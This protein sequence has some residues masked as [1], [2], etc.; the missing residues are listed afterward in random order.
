MNTPNAE[1]PEQ[2][3]RKD[4]DKY[5]CRTCGSPDIMVLAWVDGN[6]GTPLLEEEVEYP[7]VP[8]VLCRGCEAADTFFLIPE[9]P[10]SASTQQPDKP[11]TEFEHTRRE[12]EEE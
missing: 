6:T 1:V 11:D 7:E 4:I 3:A 8:T 12:G 2:V 10:F 9:Q 5:R